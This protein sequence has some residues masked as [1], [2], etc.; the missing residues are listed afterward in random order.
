MSAK[1]ESLRLQAEL[2]KI[3]IGDIAWRITEPL[4]QKGILKAKTEIVEPTFIRNPFKTY[5]NIL[6]GKSNLN[7]IRIPR[8]AIEDISTEGL[9]KLKE[10]KIHLDEKNVIAKEIPDEVFIERPSDI[11]RESSRVWLWERFGDVKKLVGKVDIEALPEELQ[12]FGREVYRPEV[13]YESSPTLQEI[14]DDIK[15][16]TYDYATRSEM[17]KF[18][19]IRDYIIRLQEKNVVIRELP[20][21]VFIERPSDVIKEGPTKVWLWE[22][23]GD[24][25]KLAEKVELEALPEELQKYGREIY[26]E[27]Y[28]PIEPLIIEERP[29]VR[30]WKAA[31]QARLERLQRWLERERGMEQTQK[32]GQKTLLEQ[33]VKEEPILELDVRS[34]V[35]ELELELE[36]VELRTN[37][38][39]PFV[40]INVFRGMFTEQAQEYP[41]VLEAEGKQGEKELEELEE[42]QFEREG[43][44]L[45]YETKMENLM[46]RESTLFAKRYREWILPKM[47][48]KHWHDFG[49]KFQNLTREKIISG[50]KTFERIKILPQ[51]KSLELLQLRELELLKLR[52]PEL[53][54]LRNL[55]QLKLRTLTKPQLRQRAITLQQLRELEL[56]KPIPLRT[57]APRV[58]KPKIPKGES[59]KKKRGKKKSSR[60]YKEVRHPVLRFEDVVGREYGKYVRKIKKRIFGR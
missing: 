45:V 42:I 20:D 2:A 1:V 40:G 30:G 50:L 25:V 59:K 47:L 15:K 6:E 52:E 35:S 29:K 18:K 8:W 31:E 28:K 26:N 14:P 46:V 13:V 39:M 44:K 27:Q 22:R 57:G 43:Y 38:M 21:E 23:F 53:L 60:S 58:R 37:L 34:L 33:K 16:L 7:V 5:K 3:K 10:Y 41:I 48:D 32:T 56:L 51:L 17:E 49:G 9:K 12:K 19:R 55:T 24:T 11:I 54:K 36:R 4:Y